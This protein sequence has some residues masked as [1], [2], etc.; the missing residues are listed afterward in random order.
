MVDPIEAPGCPSL[1]RVDVKDLVCLDVLDAGIIGE[2]LRPRGGQPDGK[3]LER[4]LIDRRDGT[5]VGPTQLLCDRSHERLLGWRC[6]RGTGGTGFQDDDVGVE[7]GSLVVARSNC[8]RGRGRDKQHSQ[9][10]KDGS[11]HFVP[12]AWVLDD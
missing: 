9:H 2:D 7:A 4:V 6:G 5:S 10:G 8:T 11:R 12:P 1:G 3:A